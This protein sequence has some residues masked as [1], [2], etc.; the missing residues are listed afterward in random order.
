MSGLTKAQRKVKPAVDIEPK[1]AAVR[2]VPVPPTAEVL[3]NSDEIDLY[4][5]Y[6]TIDVGNLGSVVW[7]GGDNVYG[8]PALCEIARRA[9]L[10]KRTTRENWHYKVPTASK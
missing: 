5:H 3:Q 10:Y 7:M 2:P 9:Q 8:D 4:H 6:G 1:E